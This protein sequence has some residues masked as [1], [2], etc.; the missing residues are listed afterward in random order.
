VGPIP[1]CIMV[2]LSLALAALACDSS[3]GADPIEVLCTGHVGSMPLMAALLERE[4]MTTAVIIPTRIHGITEVTPATIAR[5]M[6]LY[7]PRAYE[8][9]IQRYEFLLLRGIDAVYFSATQLEWMRRAFEDAGLG[10]LQ[11]RSVMSSTLGYA[12]PWAQSSTSDAFPNDASAVVAAD[13]SKQGSMEVLLNEDPS[14]P[15]IFTPYKDLLSYQAGQGGYTLMIPRE[16]SETYMWSKIGS[17]SEFSYPE[18]G[19]FPHTLGWRYGK[20]YTWS[21]MDYSG[22]GFWGQDMNPYGMD[23]YLGML[24][25]S[26]GRKLPDDVIM[27]HKL[28]I[29][30]HHYA[31]EKGFI[32]AMLNFVERFGANTDALVRK[33]A[34]MDT[35]WKQSRDLYLEQDYEGAW[36]IITSV[37]N[38]LSL[39][40]TEAL[41]AKDRALLW[42]YVVE[43]LTV[44]GTFLVAGFSLW[45]LMVRRRLYRGVLITRLIQR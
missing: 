45:T 9:L 11:D 8:E 1:R 21:L 3:Q 34:G 17:F 23:A 29:H 38:E 19:V 27:V 28:R 32:Y 12:T 20:A 13:Y 39:L 43:W 41:K 24:M 2:L 5:Y 22:S 36:P 44:S 42:I 15:A 14:L 7:F 40:R 33:I 4:P 26:T 31:E 37:L 10:G 18:P 35:S 30:F 16:G 6:R 25:Y